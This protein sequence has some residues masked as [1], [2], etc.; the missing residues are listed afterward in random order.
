MSLHQVLGLFC[1]STTIPLSHRLGHQLLFHH[2]ESVTI[3]IVVSLLNP[4]LKHPTLWISFDIITLNTLSQL[5]LNTMLSAWFDWSLSQPVNCLW[6]EPWS[7]S[8]R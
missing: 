6:F 7:W 3:G 1:N 5:H 8:W 4:I 2:P